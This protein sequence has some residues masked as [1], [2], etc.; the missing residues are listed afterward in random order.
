MNI[1][2]LS[3]II[4]ERKTYYAFDYTEEDIPD[5]LINTIITNAIWAPTHK[6][7]QP[8]RFIVL[9]G[10]HKEKIGEY[11]ADYYRTMYSEEEFS[12]ERYSET[13][14]YAL[15]ATLIAI[16][17]TPSKKLPEWEEIAAI[18]CAVQNMWLS[19]TALNIGGYW[20]TG[21]ATIEYVNNTIALATE[22]KCLGIFY[23][24]FLKKNLQQRSRRRKPLAKKL[25]KHIL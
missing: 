21:R 16:V 4:R 18:S 10:K 17:F 3:T 23:M 15:N 19:C 13:K 1:N 6:L 2:D 14:N 24:G 8:W 9:A 12:E 11:M 20:D 5:E 22:E 25:S 7:T